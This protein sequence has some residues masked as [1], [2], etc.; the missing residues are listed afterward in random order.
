MT[1][2]NIF[3]LLSPL[4]SLFL[5]CLFDIE[6]WLVILYPGNIMNLIV[7]SKRILRVFVIISIEV[8]EVKNSNNLISSSIFS[9]LID[10]GKVSRNKLNSNCDKRHPLLSPDFRGKSSNFSPFNIVL[11]TCLT[12]KFLSYW[13]SILL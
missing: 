6:F 2:G 8:H 7:N 11:A 5:V 9:C 13:Y 3:L 10:L 4:L 12:R 1:L